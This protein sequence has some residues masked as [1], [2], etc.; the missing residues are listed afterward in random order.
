MAA[1]PD[2]LGVLA[3]PGLGG[4]LLGCLTTVDANELRGLCTVARDAVAAHP[5]CDLSSRIRDVPQ[6]RACFPRAVGANIA[7][8]RGSWM[9]P[10]L[11]TS[12]ACGS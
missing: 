12:P 8:A 9:T 7:R 6:W 5:W 4:V 2:L 1:T 10:R 3:T 11:P